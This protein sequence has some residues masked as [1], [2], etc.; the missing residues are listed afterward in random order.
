M[1]KPD[2]IVPDEKA[3]EFNT[4]DVFAEKS[5]TYFD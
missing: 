5:K 3:E 1:N 2:S 4:R